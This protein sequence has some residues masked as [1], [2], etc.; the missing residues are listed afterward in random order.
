MKPTIPEIT[1]P[2]EALLTYEYVR[3]LFGVAD[4]RWIRDRVALGL[5]NRVKIGNGRRDYRITAASVKSLRAHML[6]INEEQA[7]LDR[8][9]M[10]SMREAQ[11]KPS[12]DTPSDE[13]LLDPVQITKNFNEGRRAQ[14]GATFVRVRG[15]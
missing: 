11:G 3:Q 8:A 9:R 12:T 14:R 15:I 13:V 10:Q 7:Y 1:E 4:N 6:T 2:D 5:L